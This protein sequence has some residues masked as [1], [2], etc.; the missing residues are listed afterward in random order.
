MEHKYKVEW[1]SPVTLGKGT[2]EPTK[3]GVPY[4]TALAIA[5]ESNKK[6]KPLVY[7]VKEFV[8]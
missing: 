1:F 4:H 2:V 5:D 6:Y 8:V 3:I 7:T